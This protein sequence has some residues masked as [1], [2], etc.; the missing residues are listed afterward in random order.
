[1]VFHCVVYQCSNRQGEKAKGKGI[2]FFRFPKGSKK[3]KAWIR[4][5]NRDDWAPNEY[6]RICSEHFVGGWHS[7]E[8]EDEN[9]RPTIFT[10]KEKPQ[11]D[12]DEINEAEARDRRLMQQHHEFSLY[13][14]SYCCLQPP[15]SD[16]QDMNNNS[17]FVPD[18]TLKLDD[19]DIKTFND[20]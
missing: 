9:Y 6:S 14:H 12:S 20:K 3:R 15:E 13:T 7:D 16:S 4:A 19:I 10:Y 17:T 18:E 8:V 11:T 2:S 1:M 5:I